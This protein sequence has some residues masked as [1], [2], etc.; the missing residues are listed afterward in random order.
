M[1]PPEYYLFIGALLFCIGI[2]IIIT[3]RNAIV[4]LMG[5]ELILNAANINLVAFSQ[6][7]PQRLQGQLFA[8]FVI[9]VA[10]CEAAVALAIVLRVYQYYQTI[11]LDEVSELKEE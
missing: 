4:V 3:K 1:I 11:H 8:L 6:Y 10:A 5:I 2:V 9:V 7:D